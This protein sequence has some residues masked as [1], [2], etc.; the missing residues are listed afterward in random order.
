MAADAFAR[1]SAYDRAVC[2]IYLKHGDD[3]VEMVEQPYEA[4]AV[5]Q[6]LLADYPNLLAGDD[7]AEPRRRWLLVQRELGIAGE[8]HGADRWSID[9]LFLDEEGVPTLVEVKRSSDTRLR[10]EV[11]G[12]LLDYA[13]NASA[14]WGVDKLRAAFEGR[15]GAAA[16]DQLATLLGEDVDP[17]RFWTSVGVNLHAGRLRLIFVADVIPPELRR[18]VEFLNE[19]MD[20]TEV[21]ALEVRQYVE[22]GGDRL[23]LVPRLIGATEAA[24]QAKGATPSRPKRRWGEADVL[25]AI[26]GAQAPEIARRTIALYEFLREQGARPSFGTGADPSVTIWLGEDPDPARANPIAIALYPHGTSCIAIEF[27]FVRE[28]RTPAELQRWLELLREVPGTKPALADVEAR[29]FRMIG[30]LQPEEVLASDHALAA[31]KRAVA[32]AV[33][34][35]SLRP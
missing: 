4:E 26:R 20:R 34:P 19:Q 2:A 10:R 25:D 3:L 5:L 23:T 9:Q 13:A 31:F 32:E 12:Q 7:D 16:D 18:I 1:T 22:R 33:T 15:A 11:V 28:K 35:P 8:E 27:R 21:L 30:N 29:E 14:F 17:D 24:R 6:R